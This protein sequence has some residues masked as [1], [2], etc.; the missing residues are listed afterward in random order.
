MRAPEPAARRLRRHP[1]AERAQVPRPPVAR[2]VSTI[3]LDR[4]AT[5]V[6]IP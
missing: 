5:A 3:V 4:I 2:E 1:G 6:M